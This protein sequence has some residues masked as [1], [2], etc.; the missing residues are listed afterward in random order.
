LI[1]HN[2]GAV[3]YPFNG[4]NLLFNIKAPNSSLDGSSVFKGGAGDLSNPIAVILHT[5]EADGC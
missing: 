2:L 1:H 3:K 5:L 4:S